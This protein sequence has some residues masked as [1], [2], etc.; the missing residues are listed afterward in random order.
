MPDDESQPRLLTLIEL[1][2]REK[3]LPRD[4]L[5]IQARTGRLP[6]CVKLGRRYLIVVNVFDEALR[7]GWPAITPDEARNQPPDSS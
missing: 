1:W 7:Q 3:R 4:W 5:Y 2:R 6:G